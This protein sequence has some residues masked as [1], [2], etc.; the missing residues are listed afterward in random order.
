MSEYVQF[1]ACRRCFFRPLNMICINL[2][3]R[4]LHSQLV[5]Q[6]YAQRRRALQIKKHAKNFGRSPGILCFQG[7]NNSVICRGLVVHAR[8][9]DAVISKDFVHA[10]AQNAVISRDFVHAKAQN[11]VIS[12]DFVHAKAHNA[13]ISR[14][15]V[16]P[17]VQNV[18]ISKNVACIVGAPVGLYRLSS[19]NCQSG[20]IRGR[21]P[22]NKTRSLLQN[23]FRE[24]T[25]I[26]YV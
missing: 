14:D 4:S 1:S 12:G 8:A 24:R 9:Q 10:R 26:E 3:L 17:R 21:A 25:N 2:A 15:L 19:K 13:V 11:A 7:P 20:Q 6:F 22:C 5:A 18:V 23:I 16:H